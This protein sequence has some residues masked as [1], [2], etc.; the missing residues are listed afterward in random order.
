MI[1]KRRRCEACTRK[2]R[3]REPIF[4]LKMMTRDGMSILKVCDE[5]ANLLNVMVERLEQHTEDRA[6]G[7]DFDVDVY[8]PLS[9]NND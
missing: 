7:L 1:F 5:C 2:L 6:L 9:E 8:D 3:K 4:E